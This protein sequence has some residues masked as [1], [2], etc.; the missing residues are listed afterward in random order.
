MEFEIVW[1]GAMKTSLPGIGG[2]ERRGSYLL[3]HAPSNSKQAGDF[4]RLNPKQTKPKIFSSAIT[5]PCKGGCGRYVNIETTR[6][7]RC[8]QARKGES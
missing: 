7:K 6:C 4:P 1:S 3:D 2:I 8:Q 5:R